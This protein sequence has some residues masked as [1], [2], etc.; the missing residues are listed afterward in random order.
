MRKMLIIL[1]IS[2]NE[3]W[4]KR[5]RKDDFDLNNQTHSGRTLETKGAEL[6]ELQDTTRSEYDTVKEFRMW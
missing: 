4:F 1:Y 5:F 6:Q 2:T 3:K